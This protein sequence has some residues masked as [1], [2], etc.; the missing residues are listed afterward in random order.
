MS[1]FVIS[2]RNPRVMARFFSSHD[3]VYC[4]SLN[5][6]ERSLDL[7]RCRNTT[8]LGPSP[9]QRV[10]RRERCG[11]FFDSMWQPRESPLNGS[12]FFL[13]SLLLLS[14]GLPERSTGRGGY[15]QPRRHGA[16]SE[17]P[18]GLL[19]LTWLQL[20]QRALPPFL[21]GELRKSSGLQFLYSDQ[22]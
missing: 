1:L 15:E 14:S 19:G 6:L 21:Y 11:P 12:F 2:S 22:L 17:I 13:S 10:V 9:K 8:S 18:L 4:I 16:A 20:L 7:D 5:Y 3:Q